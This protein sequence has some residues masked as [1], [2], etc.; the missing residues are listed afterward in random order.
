MNSVKDPFDLNV[1]IKKVWQASRDGRA[2]SIFAML[3]NLDREVIVNEVLNHHTDENGQSTTPLIIAARNG[4][5]KVVQILLRHF[6]ADLEQTGVVKFDGYSIEGATALWCAAGAGHFNIVKLLIDQGAD[7]NHAT[8]TNSTP[9]RAACFDGRLDIVQYLIDH[10]ADLLIANKYKNTCLMISCYKG[11][12]DV[13]EYL[14]AKGAPANTRAHCGATALHFSAECGHLA[15][16]E[17]LINHGALMLK[18]DNGMTPL[19]VAAECAQAEVVEYLT[20]TK[21]CELME[22]IDAFELLGATFANDKEHYDLS[23][24]YQ[25][26]NKGMV[27]RFSDP[28]NTVEKVLPAPVP[29]YHNHVEC[30]TLHDVEAIKNNPG[31]LHMEGLAI[32]E[33]I[34]GRHNPEVPHPIIFRGAFFADTANFD[35]CILLWLHALNLRQ[36]SHRS[37]SKDLLRFAQV[38]AQMT[39]LGIEPDYKSVREVFVHGTLELQNDLQRLLK[40]RDDYDNL[41]EIFEENIHT[42]LY[43]LVIILKIKIPN[44]KIEDM[45]KCV[46]RFLQLKPNLR[47]G[48][49]PLHMVTDSATIVDDFHVNDVVT[50]PCGNLCKLLIDCG[51][52]IDA[53][54]N[55]GNTPLHIIVQYINPINDFENLHQCM[56]SLIMAGAH[57]DICNG[58]GKTALDVATTGVAEVIIR[59]NN[60][61]S[62]KCMSAKIIK[63]FNIPCKGGIPTILEEFVELH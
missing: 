47:N 53:Q 44:E 57:L 60:R 22:K 40:N 63:K 27:E 19:M 43:I 55:L 11:H 34:L 13:V 39:H 31:L 3:W 21:E 37:I 29:A 42:C 15:I 4:E 56:I 49:T 52:D 33:R 9:L 24:S 51:A 62:L 38:F 50:F 32:R 28:E 20:N 2:I 16:V 35:R 10:N 30:K 18:N 7:V 48:Y 17:A 36:E 54:D 46:Y 12:K 23:K 1:L 14:L 8:V 58:D 59:T 6:K 5:E 41:Q 25:Y 26:L 45:H 61:I